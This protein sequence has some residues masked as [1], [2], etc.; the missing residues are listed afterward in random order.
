MWGD[1]NKIF[2]FLPQRLRCRGQASWGGIAKL[3]YNWHGIP[4]R[5][6]C[7]YLLFS[8]LEFILLFRSSRSS[9]R[10]NSVPLVITGGKIF[11]FSIRPITTSLWY[12][13]FPFLLDKTPPNHHITSVTQVTKDHTYGINTIRYIP[14]SLSYT[15]LEQEYLDRIWPKNSKIIF[16]RVHLLIIS[17]PPQNNAFSQTSWG[18]L[19]RARKMKIER[20]F[21]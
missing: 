16:L 14:E 21:L 13:Y 18:N 17:P 20:R 7:I 8:S 19:D 2:V 4:A 1:V 6:N 9:L 11:R 5:C 10:Y 12:F 15:F 3:I